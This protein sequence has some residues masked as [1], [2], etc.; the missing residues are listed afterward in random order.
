M[1]ASGSAVEAG[2]TVTADV[3]IVGAGAAGITIAQALADTRLR[4]VVLESGG[5]EADPATQRLYRGQLRGSR[6]PPLDASRLRYFG[7][8]TNHWVGWCGPLAAEDFEVRSWVPDSGWPITRADLDPWYLEAQAVCDLGPYDYSSDSWGRFAEP[9]A[10]LT[11]RDLEL[12]LVQ[13]SPPTRFGAKYR[14]RLAGAKNIEVLLDSN[15]VAFTPDREAATIEY[16][17]VATLAGRRFRVAARRYVVAC[18]AVENARL[19]LSSNAVVKSGLGNDRDL[20]GR[21]YMDHPRVRP[22]GRMFASSP[23]AAR[24]AGFARKD[25]VRATL[26][27]SPSFAA[28]RRGRIGNS[29]AFTESAQPLPIA[30]RDRPADVAVARF[31]QRLEGGRPHGLSEWWVRSEQSPNRDSRI[32][33]GPTRDALGLRRPILDWRISELDRRTLTTSAL[34][35][36]EDLTAAGLARVQI[37]PWLASGPAVEAERVTGDWHQLGTTRMAD[38]PRRGVVDADCRVH[39]IANLFVAGGSVFPTSG[40]MNPTLTVVALALRLARRLRG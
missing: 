36:S 9:I 27:V 18:G 12:R 14:A 8:T 24:L 33:L 39:G 17:E 21:Y 35:I 20:V 13:H 25:G 40:A 37:E 26:A 6:Q 23:D 7:G 29:M 34:R 1:I 4:V 19:L 15:L 5:F 31:L 32:T 28:Q 10:A 3:C 11:D 22:A 30:K 16:A 38:S 2:S